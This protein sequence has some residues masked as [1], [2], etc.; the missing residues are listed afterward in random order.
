MADDPLITYAIPIDDDGNVIVHNTKIS[1]EPDG[2]QK[3]VILPTPGSE[4]NFYA[5]NMCDRCCWYTSSTPVAHEELT[6]SDQTTYDSVNEWWIDLTHGRVFK[7]DALLAANAEYGVTVEVQFGGTGDWIEQT[8]NSWGSSDDG[9]FSCNYE[10]GTITFNS[11]KE[12]DPTDKVRASYSHATSYLY[13][14]VPSAGKMLKVVYAEVQYM[15]DINFRTNVDFAIEAGGSTVT[16]YKFKRLRNFYEESIGPYPVIP[17]HG[18]ESEVV[19]VSGLSAINTKVEQGYRVLGMRYDEIGSE[20][21]A[22]MQGI[23]ANGGRAMRKPILTVP[24]H[25]NAFVP[26]YSTMGM[27]IKITLDDV[28]GLG[29]SFGNITFYCMSETDPNA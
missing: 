2:S 29:G 9:D 11:G 16:S 18:G 4:K 3:T 5:P 14:V 24:F 7:E 27:K 15:E 20:W 12:K 23:K 28:V 8:E 21:I 19:E 10:A 25:Y 6:T 22:L 26:L 13:E 17:P 1:V